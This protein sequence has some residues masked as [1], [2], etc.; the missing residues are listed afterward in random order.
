MFGLCGGPASFRVKTR[1]SVARQIH[2]WSGAV[3][4]ALLFLIS[5][6]GT[7][8]VF[9]DDYLRATVPE[10]RAVAD[11]SASALTDITVRAETVFGPDV[12]R[13]L[14]FATDDLGLHK[15]YLTNG[16]SAYLSATGAVIARWDQ[17]GRVEDW[18]FDLHHRLLLGDF[19]LYTAG[20]AGV[21]GSLLV[22]TGLYAVW[23]MRKGWRRGLKIT[24]ASRTQLR[25]LHRNLGTLS[26][27]PILLLMLT[28][29]AMVWSSQTRA[30][31]DWWGAPEPLPTI[32]VSPDPGIAPINW[33]AGFAGAA[34]AFPEAVPRMAIWP[35][36]QGSASLRLKQP[37]EWHPNGRTRFVFT[38]N[39][40]QSED[41]L[42]L[43]AG[44]EAFNAIYPIHA[45]NTGHGFYRFLTA[46]IGLAL[47]MLSLLGLISFAK[48]F[49]F[50]VFRKP[51][52]SKKFT[53]HADRY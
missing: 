33:A 40:G 47:T 50:T 53:T 7:L 1:Y 30:M 5:A 17:N 3:L 51:V 21:G 46:L 29:A 49:S 36:D 28:G 19:G 27:V 10:A 13:A 38:G 44:R 18:V 2:S 6:T 16:R 9:K 22:L 26:A 32:T 41:A 14:V 24:A 20:V 39:F 15:A 43:G 31:F 12:L 35:R 48:R 45:G 8:L 52:R 34:Q 37:D 25:S 42:T 4:A 23:P 11:L